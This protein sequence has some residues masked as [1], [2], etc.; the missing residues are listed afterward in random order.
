MLTTSSAVS[1]SQPFARIRNHAATLRTSGCFLALAPLGPTAGRTCQRSA[2]RIGHAPRPYRTSA[3]APET[4]P[5]T[6]CQSGCL[7]RMRGHRARG[8]TKDTFQGSCGHL[9]SH[10][11]SAPESPLKGRR[12]FG[13]LLTRWSHLRLVMRLC[14]TLARAACWEK[15]ACTNWKAP[16]HNSR[17]SSSDD[18][19]PRRGKSCEYTVGSSHLWSTITESRA[20]DHGRV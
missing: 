18:G 19:L 14:H 4:S 1:K 15:K 5:G 8:A 13:R 20:S 6:A 9:R 2:A 10:L 16:S 3:E 12:C 11:V 7:G 17:R